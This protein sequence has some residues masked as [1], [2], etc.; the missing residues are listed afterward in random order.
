[1]PNTSNYYNKKCKRE[2]HHAIATRNVIKDNAM[3]LG[4]KKLYYEKNIAMIKLLTL[5]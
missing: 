1:M 5:L 2:K 3:L 4:G